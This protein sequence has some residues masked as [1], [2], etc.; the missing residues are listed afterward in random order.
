MTQE[1]LYSKYNNKRRNIC[2]RLKIP[3]ES[4]RLLYLMYDVFRLNGVW[5]WI[6]LDNLITTVN[7]IHS[8]V[9]LAFVKDF[10]FNSI[11]YIIEILNDEIN[12]EIYDEIIDFII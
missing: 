5:T 8:Y 7:I 2:L 9:A 11:P 4:I 6:T 10:S 1:V 12:D 3:K